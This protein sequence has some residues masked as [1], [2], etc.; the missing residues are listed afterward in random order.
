MGVAVTARHFISTQLRLLAPQPLA[1]ALPPP[2]S[3]TLPP[4]IRHPPDSASDLPLDFSSAF[5]FTRQPRAE[6]VGI[7]RHRLH[8][9]TS[10]PLSLSF[11]P[12]P[13]RALI[14]RR[15]SFP[16]E[17]FDLLSLPPSLFL[18]SLSSSLSPSLVGGLSLPPSLFLLLHSAKLPLSRVEVR[19]CMPL[20]AAAPC[21]LCRVPAA[22][23]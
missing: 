13:D 17:A 2:H 6:F 22:R 3:N 15:C 16:G 14:V 9:T 23:R 4:Q 5:T 21:L 18:L 11:S 1:N 12:P 7:L 20:L 8:H 10:S 19:G